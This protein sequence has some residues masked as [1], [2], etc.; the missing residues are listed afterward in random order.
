MVWRNEGHTSTFLGLFL[1]T[2]AAILFHWRAFE[3]AVYQNR[4]C[5]VLAKNNVGM[6]L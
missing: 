4:K 5:T 3:M 1:L 6:I 2:L